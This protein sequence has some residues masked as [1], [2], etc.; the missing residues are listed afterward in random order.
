MNNEVKIQSFTDL[1]AW[2]EGHKLVLTIYNFTDSF[3][4]KEIFCLTSQIRRAAISIT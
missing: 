2:E 4:K 3:P 1:N